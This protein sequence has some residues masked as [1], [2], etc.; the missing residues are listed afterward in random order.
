MMNLFLG[1]VSREFAD[2]SVILQVQDLRRDTIY[3]VLRMDDSPTETVRE[4]YQQPKFL[5]SSQQL[6]QVNIAI[7]GK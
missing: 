5:S 2:Y 4:R 7:Y 6:K 1:Q 3:G